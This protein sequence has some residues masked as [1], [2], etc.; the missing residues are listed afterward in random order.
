MAA[1]AAGAMF[2]GVPVLIAAGALG[3]A[4]QAG[5]AADAAALAAA[6]AM[7]GLTAAEIE[8]CALAAELVALHGARLD[9]CSLDPLAFEARVRA[10]VSAGPLLIARSARAGPANW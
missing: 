7:M 5:I 3:A 4:A 6:D 2:L 8:P 1:V 10:S 9:R